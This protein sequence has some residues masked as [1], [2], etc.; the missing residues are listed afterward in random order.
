M[1]RFVGCD[2]SFI[3]DI[4]SRR[5]K[6][7]VPKVRY[8]AEILNIKNPIRSSIVFFLRFLLPLKKRQRIRKF[9]INLNLTTPPPLDKELKSKLMDIFREDI[10]KLQKLIGRD[11]SIWFG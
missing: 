1:F 3:P 2:D 4:R 6:G 5:Q 10:L 8:A 11:L 7:A 9:L